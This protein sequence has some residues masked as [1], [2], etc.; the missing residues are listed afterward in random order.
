MRITQYT[1]IDIY[2]NDCDKKLIEKKHKE[3]LKLGYLREA[4]GTGTEDFKYCDQYLKFKR[5]RKT[6]K[7]EK[8]KCHCIYVDT[9][10]SLKCKICGESVGDWISREIKNDS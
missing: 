3:L 6:T 2:Y 1:Y 9:G 8:G 10:T 5:R 4:Q 7:I